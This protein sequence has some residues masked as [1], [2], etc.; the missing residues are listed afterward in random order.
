MGGA[1]LDHWMSG[2]ENFTIVDPMLEKAPDGVRLV[3]DRSAIADDRFD[4][5]IVAIKPQMIDDVVPAYAPNL[6]DDGYVLSIAA[7]ASAARL[8]KAMGGA[9]V[10]RVM[11]NLPAAVGKGTSG[12]LAG[13]DVS[14][15]QAS[16]AMEMMQRTGT[17]IAVEN[18]DVLDRATAVAGSGPGYVFEIARA[19]VAAAEKLGFAPDQARALVLGTMEGTIAMALANPDTPLEELRNSVTSKGGTT[20]AGLDALNGDGGLSETLNATLQSAYDRAVELR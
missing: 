7:G 19:Y 8:K 13:P 17:A 15:A 6:A 2:G 5:I 16:H 4:T 20:A 12:V 18:E 9:P 1:L 14:E 3:K 11:P 10:V